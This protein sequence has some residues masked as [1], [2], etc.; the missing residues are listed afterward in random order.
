MGFIQMKFK[1]NKQI[2]VSVLKGMTYDNVGML[3]NISRERVY[4]IT[5]GILERVDPE[6]V[7]QQYD[8]R[9]FRLDSDRLIGLIAKL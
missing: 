9:I 4:Q 6:I 3:Y 5:K 2:A 1:R 7:K 8:I